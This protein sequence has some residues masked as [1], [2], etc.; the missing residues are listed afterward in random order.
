MRLDR[1]QLL[2]ELFLVLD[3]ALMLVLVI[4]CGQHSS[5]IVQIAYK[6]VDLLILI[7]SDK[8]GKSLCNLCNSFGYSISTSKKY[9]ISPSSS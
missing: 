6:L 3:H 2:Y 1:K 5:F 4:L 8:N 9:P 7:L